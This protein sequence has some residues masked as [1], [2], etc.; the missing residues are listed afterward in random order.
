M[1]A[2][3]EHFS[4]KLIKTDQARAAGAADGQ[5]DACAIN[6]AAAIVPTPRGSALI[7]FAAE[8]LDAEIVFK[9]RLPNCLSVSQAEAAEFAAARL[10]IEAVAINQRCGTRASAPL[11]L[12]NLR[13]WTAP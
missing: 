3:P 11:I 7:R 4:G 9:A 8:E 10:H 12:K 13:V 5:D 2:L 1:A 6:Y